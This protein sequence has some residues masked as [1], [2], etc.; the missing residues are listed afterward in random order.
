[1]ARALQDFRTVLGHFATGVAVAATMC[2]G[3]PSGFERML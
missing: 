2:G 1:V 3:R